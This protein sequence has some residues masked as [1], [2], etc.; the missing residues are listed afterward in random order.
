MLAGLDNSHCSVRLFFADFKTGF[1]LV[2]HNAIVQE[3]FNI[4]VHPILIQW[5]KSFLTDREQCVKTDL[6]QSS[7]RKTNGGLP[8]GTRPGQ[9]LFSILV[10]PLLSDWQGRVEFVDDATALEIIPRCSPSL[11]PM[12][13]DKMFDFAQSRGMMLNPKKCKEM[14]VSFLKYN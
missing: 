1:D 13:V 5:V 3:L 4:N 7:W 14:I 11:M 12:V 10:S 8:Q 2:D 6:Y 9:L